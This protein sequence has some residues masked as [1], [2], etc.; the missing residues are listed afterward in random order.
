MSKNIS[1]VEIFSTGTWHGNKTISVSEND[2]HTMVNSFNELTSKVAGFRPFLKLGHSEMQ[3]FFGGETGAPSLGFVDKIW[4]EG[5]KVLANFSNVPDALVDLMSKGRYNSVS[6]EFLPSVNFE[7]SIF[8][9]VLRAVALLGAELPAVKGLKELSATLMSEFAYEFDDAEPAET[10][11]KE[12]DMP[13]TDAKFSQEQVDALIEAAVEKAVATAKTSLSD[14]VEALKAEVEALKEDNTKLAEGKAAVEASMKEF[15]AAS[16][17]KDIETLIDK[18]IDEGKIL[19]AQREHYIALAQLN[20]TVK[21]GDSEK[22]ARKVIEDLLGAAQPKVDLSEGL[23]S[24]KPSKAE[25]EGSPQEIVHA[26]TIE[27]VTASEG[28]FDYATAYKQVLASD[29]ELS[30][31]YAAMEE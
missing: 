23:G 28:K 16:E 18:G 9:N 2:L 12:L 13:N 11:E 7:G 19:P 21:F 31:Q 4:V 25:I 29:P 10:L 20:Q 22:S 17:Q 24:K 30:A 5:N 26:R 15:V 8:K 6:I 27:L 14:Q 1:N 3:K